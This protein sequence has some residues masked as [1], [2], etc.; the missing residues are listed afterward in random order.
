M[1]RHS[2]V[3]TNQEFSLPNAQSRNECSKRLEAAADSMN[4]RGARVNLANRHQNL[5]W[6]SYEFG[7]PNFILRSCLFKALQRNRREFV[8]QRE[9]SS[10]DRIKFLV[11]GP[12][13]NQSDL[14]VL[15]GF[16]RLAKLQNFANIIKFNE[17]TFLQFID[18][19][20]QGGKIG[21]SDRDWL[22][23]TI[24]RLGLTIMTFTNG[25][26]E[27]AGALIVEYIRDGLSGYYVVSLNPHFFEFYG[28]DNWTKLNI[29]V[30][31]SLRGNPLAQFLYG[32]YR[33]NACTFPLKVQTLH[34][35]S[36]SEAGE[37]TNT[38]AARSKAL[39]S[40][41][42]D[43]LRPALEKLQLKLIQH[44]QNFEWSIDTTNLVTVKHQPSKS[45]KRH[46]DK[47]YQLQ[48]TNLRVS[49]H[50]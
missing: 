39:S 35:I 36:G 2:D 46:L 26:N 25:P 21:K 15:I 9:V 41:R 42:D 40:W 20:G 12:T 13:L 10:L 44:G 33:S 3:G 22:R 28:L 24:S 16:V 37:S 7:L 23:K 19:G 17:R 4:S 11:T 18:R 47:K 48:S 5:E 43:T 29:D 45:Q 34:D 38:K 49:T 31:N 27:Y 1:R 32:F 8:S 30:R 50:R 6:Y 14:D